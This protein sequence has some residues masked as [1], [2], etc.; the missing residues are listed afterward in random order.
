MRPQ[1]TGRPQ[2]QLT[3]FERLQY[4]G[5]SNA[6]QVESAAVKGASPA[7]LMGEEGSPVEPCNGNKR[8]RRHNRQ[9]EGP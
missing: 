9:T 3:V 1:I 4:I 6:S 8:R 2:P 5:S 7:T